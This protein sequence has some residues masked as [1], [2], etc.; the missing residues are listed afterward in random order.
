MLEYISDTFSFLTK[1]FRLNKN[2]A[3]AIVLG[4]LCGF[5]SASSAIDNLYQNNKISKKDAYHLISFTNNASPIFIFSAVGTTILSSKEIG[6]K[7]L[8]IH[9]LSSIVLGLFYS[10]LSKDNN[11]IQEKTYNLKIENKKRVKNLNKF[12]I[13]KTCIIDSFKTMLFILAYMI[14]FNLLADILNSYNLPCIKYITATFELTKGISNISVYNNIPYISFLLGFS[15]FSIIFQIRSSL[16]TLDYPIS[17]IIKSKL[18]HGII[19]YI[20]AQF[21]F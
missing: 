1:I 12:D 15:S 14:L 5:P 18:L 16:K 11:I 2:C 10:F 9:I 6:I 19:S 13:L 4:F 17:K 21:I 20:I 7:L 3:S 8:F